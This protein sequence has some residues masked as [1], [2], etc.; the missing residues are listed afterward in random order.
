MAVAAE[1][2]LESVRRRIE[3]FTRTSDTR[4]LCDPAGLRDAAALLAAADGPPGALA[5]V[6]LLRHARHLVRPADEDDGDELLSHADAAEIEA[7]RRAAERPPQPAPELP[8]VEHLVMALLNASLAVLDDLVARIRY[9]VSDP[10][11]VDELRYLVIAAQAR[12]AR[13]GRTGAVEDLEDAVATMAEAVHRTPDDHEWYPGR[14]SQLGGLLQLR[15]AVSGDRRD[16][17]DGIEV[18]RTAAGAVPAGH[19]DWPM[20]RSN[21][22]RALLFRYGMAQDEADLDEAM[23]ML[24]DAVTATA[25]DEIGSVAASRL[26][27]LQQATLARYHLHGDPNDL[28]IALGMA[29]QAWEAT[30]EDDHNRIER[31][32]D[33]SL[34]H[35]AVYR[36]TDEP[37]HAATAEQLAE[38]V[39]GTTE[40]EQ[41]EQQAAK[42]ILDEVRTHRD[43][44]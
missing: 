31:T 37:G 12:E 19:Q 2:L 24:T 36:C 35:L 3:W 29:R 16:L 7:V 41:A 27:L 30:P 34:A 22:G 20:F 1:E 39:M 26:G 38:Q 4:D 23:A 21:L 8:P 28:G 9:G 13:W 42:A 32:L 44:R 5:A 18:I 43:R 11:T 15:F 14:S 25:G 40:P 6:G 33:L 10:V 17:D